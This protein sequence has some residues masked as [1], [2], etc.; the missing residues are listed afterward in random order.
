MTETA[1]ADKNRLRELLEAFRDCSW[2]IP[3]EASK[4]IA[5]NLHWTTCMTL[6]NGTHYV[7]G[8]LDSAAN[9]PDAKIS[10]RDG[11]TVEVTADLCNFD[12][13]R[14]A[15]ELSALKAASVRFVSSVLGESTHQKPDGT[16]WDLDNAGRIWV[17]KCSSSV[18]LEILSPLYA[19]VERFEAE[20]GIPNDRQIGQG[21]EADHDRN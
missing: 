20:Y 2:P 10:Y 18:V 8:M 4:A 17:R 16:C 21:S 14:P 3:A 15:S 6:R 1:T 13:N 12:E 5:E 11:E 9:V 7:S 19:D